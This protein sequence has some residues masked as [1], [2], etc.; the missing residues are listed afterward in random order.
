MKRLLIWAGDRPWRA[1]LVALA[2]A[3][4][5]GTGLPRVRFD[6]SI[7]S[8]RVPL[9]GDAATLAARTEAEEA[10]GGQSVLTVIVQAPEL[11]E[12]PILRA[13]EEM[14]WQLQGLDGVQ[15]VVSLATVS[16]LEARDGFLDTEPLLAWVPET[17]EELL[18]LRRRTLDQAIL[19]GEVV[20]EAGTASA[21][22][23]FVS[24]QLSDDAMGSLRR[25]VDR[26]V[27]GTLESLRS[28]T[29]EAADRIDV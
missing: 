26:A 6:A 22:H 24:N 2:L 23:V 27:A 7:E 9:R 10:F 25:E 13:V 29:P 28:T 21:L 4:L 1:L 11:F 3:A 14:T 12:T 5:F 19:R 8:L 16:A 20:N 17:P 18:D 15:R